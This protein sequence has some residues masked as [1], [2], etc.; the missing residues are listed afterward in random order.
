[1]HYP[2]FKKREYHVVLPQEGMR[3]PV[4]AEILHTFYALK[5][6]I[7]VAKEMVETQPTVVVWDGAKVNWKM[8]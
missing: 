6:A 7:D 5:D 4:G 3:L 2:Q 1:M 8:G